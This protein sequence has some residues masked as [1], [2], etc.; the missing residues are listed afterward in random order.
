LAS[1]IRWELE[2]KLLKNSFNN[3]EDV[4]VK[5]DLCVGCG[6]C[7]IACPYNAIEIVYNYGKGVFYPRVNRSACK[8]CG[9]CL[10]VC[11]SVRFFL[12]DEIFESIVHLLRERIGVVKRVYIGYASD[13]QLRFYASSGG[14]VTALLKYLFD[15]KYIDGAIVVT[16]SGGEVPVA[17]AVVARSVDEAMSAMG[18]KYVPPLFNDAVRSIEY[19]KS[20]AFVG[21]PCHIYAM[22]Q[23]TK[24]SKKLQGSIKLYIGL[25]C[26]GVLSYHCLEYLIRRYFKI[27]GEYRLK[28]VRFRGWGW[29]GYMRIKIDKKDLIVSFPEY[30]PLIA[31]RF[32]LNP[33]LTCTFSFNPYAD[34]VCGDA[35]LEDIVKRDRVGTSIVVIRTERGEKIFNE[36]VNN[37]Y[38]KSV[39]LNMDEFFKAEKSLISDK[40]L[41]LQSRV[42]SLKKLRKGTAQIKL[43]DTFYPSI[44]SFH[45]ELFINCLRFFAFRKKWYL[46]DILYNTYKQ[47]AIMIA[48]FLRRLK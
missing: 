33:C 2:L 41:L 6:M 21:L 16:M 39:P 15:K 19:G 47:G 36:A 20:Y 28:D 40:F 11:P 45:N 4:I 10:N 12:K 26:G 22:Q 27:K 34:V 37:G 17:R 3:V 32:R 29:P 8:N 35:W 5:K 13:F 44:F 23:Y 42:L 31:P 14:I 30:W 7:E 24:M 25:L 18:S 38:V 48:R 43:L 9:V 46:A 1:L